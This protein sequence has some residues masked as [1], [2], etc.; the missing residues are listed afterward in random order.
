MIDQAKRLVGAE[1][2]KVMDRCIADAVGSGREAEL[3]DLIEEAVE[4]RDQGDP[5]TWSAAA[6]AAPNPVSTNYFVTKM[7]ESMRE[8]GVGNMLK[9]YLLFGSITLEILRLDNN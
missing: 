3:V 5:F 4:S 1:S 8:G 2:K 9:E 7:I 6:R